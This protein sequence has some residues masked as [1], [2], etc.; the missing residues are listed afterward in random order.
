VRQHAVERHQK[1]LAREE[2]GKPE[3]HKSFVNRKP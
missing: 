1:R 3:F 2:F